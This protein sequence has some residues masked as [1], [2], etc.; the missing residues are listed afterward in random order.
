M[1]KIDVVYGGPTFDQN[2]P[3]GIPSNVKIHKNNQV[4]ESGM[5]LYPAGHASN[6]SANLGQILN[7]KFEKL[8]GLALKEKDFKQLLQKLNNLESLSAQELRE[9]YRC[10][11]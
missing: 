9:L 5:V 11:I 8:G 4:F 10:D 1:K 7:N 3:K 2:Y 6:T